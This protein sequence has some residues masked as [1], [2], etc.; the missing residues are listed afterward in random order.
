[1]IPLNTV[2]WGLVVLFGVIGSLRGWAKEVLVAFSVLLSLFIQQVFGQF[3]LGTENP[4]LPMLLPVSD[5]VPP[6]AYNTTQFYVCVALLLLLTFFG[7]ASPTLAQRIGAK[8]VR[9]RLQD[10]LLGFFLGI[11]NGYLI[12]GT[13]WFYL[14]KASYAVGGIMRPAEGT[15]ALVIATQYLLP[16]WLTASILYV[17]IALAFV[18]VIIVFV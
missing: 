7:Y 6:E 12:V 8:M 5:A 16:R 2:F 18:F 17:A 13:L 14:D 15:A 10:A 11:M 3:V 1:M 9:E 4:Y